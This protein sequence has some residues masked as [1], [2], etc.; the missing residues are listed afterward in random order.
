[1]RRLKKID[2]QLLTGFLIDKNFNVGRSEILLTKFAGAKAIHLEKSLAKDA[3][4]KKVQ[5][6]GFYCVVWS[7]NE[8]A[9]MERL[10]NMRVD[11][12]ITDKPDLLK[13]INVSLHHA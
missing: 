7:V 10:T 12:I 13:N 5:T 3:F 11:A 2:D 6:L 4:I 8:P 1:M 9:M